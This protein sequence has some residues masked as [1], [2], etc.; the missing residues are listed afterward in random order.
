[1][2]LARRYQLQVWAVRLDRPL[3]L[4][5][6]RAVS[7]VNHEGEQPNL[8]P[9]Q[10]ATNVISHTE[11]LRTSTPGASPQEGKAGP[12]QTSRPVG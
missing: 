7:R 2:H 5:V 4:C 11:G 1:M 9:G 8:A 6:A 12:R 10:R 3:E